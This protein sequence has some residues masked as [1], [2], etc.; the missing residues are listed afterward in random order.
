MLDRKSGC[1]EFFFE[2]IV[3]S[4]RTI[5]EY[6]FVFDFLPPSFLVTMDNG[7]L[8]QK[9]IIKRVFVCDG[10]LIVAMREPLLPLPLQNPLD[11]DGG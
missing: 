11:H 8:K 7:W 5:L 1:V 6:F 9:E 10:P 2:Y 3:C 4:K